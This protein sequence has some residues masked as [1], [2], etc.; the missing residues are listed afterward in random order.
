MLADCA[1]RAHCR[2]EVDNGERPRV[3]A[4]VEGQY[5]GRLLHTGRSPVRRSAPS[6]NDPTREISIGSQLL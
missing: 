6:A 3:H 1:R 2:V 4:E 5:V